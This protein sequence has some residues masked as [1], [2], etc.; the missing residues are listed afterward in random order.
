MNFCFTSAVCLCLPESLIEMP[1]DTQ[2]SNS[3]QEETLDSLGALP[4]DSPAGA[5]E[6]SMDNREEVENIFDEVKKKPCKVIEVEVKGFQRTNPD[7][8]GRELE[9][10]KEAKN[11]EEIRNEL[12]HIFEVFQELDVFSEIDVDVEKPLEVRIRQSGCLEE[13]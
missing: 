8:V 7:V 12:M 3:I 4:G 11:L 5:D 13:T 10:V 6:G 9:R 1:D 2:S